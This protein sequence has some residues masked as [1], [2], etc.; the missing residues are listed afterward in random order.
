MIGISAIVIFAV[1]LFVTSMLMVPRLVLAHVKASRRDS[2][3]ALLSQL[4]QTMKTY[5]QDYGSFPP[6]GG[7][8]HGV[9]TPVLDPWGRPLV[10]RH[11]RTISTTQ[12]STHK[13]ITWKEYRVHSVGPNGIDEDGQGDDVTSN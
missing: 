6:G 12:R 3:Q 7:S 13:V 4:R 9:K 8:I 2:C 11:V 5:Q 1:G 10:F